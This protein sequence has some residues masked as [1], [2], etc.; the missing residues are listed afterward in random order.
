ML[1]YLY[2]EQKSASDFTFPF[3]L[4]HIVVASIKESSTIMVMHNV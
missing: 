4:G 2:S 1:D 3:S